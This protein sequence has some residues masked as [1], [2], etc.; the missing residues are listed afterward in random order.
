M[1]NM[2]RISNFQLFSLLVLFQ[3]GTTILFGIFSDSGR[4]AWIAVLINAALG[5]AEIALYL[6]LMRQHPGLTLVEWFPARF[7][8]WLGTPLAW[9]FP[10]LFLYSAGRTVRDLM[11]V[12]EPILLPR[13]PSLVTVGAML[14]VICYVSYNGI[15]TLSRVCETLLFI[16][17][18]AFCIQIA[19]IFS[20]PQLVSFRHLQPVLYEGWG[21]IWKSV[22]PLGITQSY[23][24]TIEFAMIWPLVHRPGQVARSTVYATLFAT[25]IILVAVTLAISVLGE[26]LFKRSTIPLYSVLGEV[27]VGDFIENLN[28]LG[29]LYLSTMT[30][31]KT[32]LHFWVSVRGISRLTRMKDDRGL[33]IPL[34]IA[35]VVLAHT[36]AA[37][38]SEH[39]YIGSKVLTLYF[40]A[41]VYLGLPCLLAIAVLMQKWMKPSG[42]LP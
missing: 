6:W 32:A 16:V 10:L 14:L 42:T 35:V 20:S 11:E 34:A 19:L 8:K 38:S 29:V 2:E 30:F 5:L 24:Q 33:I 22:W 3:V 1:I 26:Q 23:A 25:V 36:M 27:K 13:T 21:R 18:G 40:W 9:L 15:E 39:V 4:D 12:I 31:C 41:P 28:P 17:V 37:N 7:G